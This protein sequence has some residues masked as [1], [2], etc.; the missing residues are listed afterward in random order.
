MEVNRN[1]MSNME[2]LMELVQELYDYA[3]K[4][5]FELTL[6]NLFQIGFFFFCLQYIV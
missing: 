4:L 5:A 6:W 3:W 1:G 2:F